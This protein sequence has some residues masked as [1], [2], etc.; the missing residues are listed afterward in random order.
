MIFHCNIGGGKE[1]YYE[2]ISE[3]FESSS[4]SLIGKSKNS[5]RWHHHSGDVEIKSHLI[6]DTNI[7]YICLVYISYSFY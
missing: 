3:S 1:T 4:A 2:T 5:S 6:N 7:G